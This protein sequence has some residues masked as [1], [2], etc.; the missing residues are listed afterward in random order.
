MIKNFKED[1][2]REH[3]RCICIKNIFMKIVSDV[4][5]MNESRKSGILKLNHGLLAKRLVK[6]RFRVKRRTLLNNNDDIIEYA[7]LGLYLVY[8]FCKTKIRNNVLSR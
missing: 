4:H 2:F 6:A 7:E 3:L 1:R 5:K 8:N